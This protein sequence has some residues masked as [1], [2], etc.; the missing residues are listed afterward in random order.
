MEEVKHNDMTTVGEVATYNAAKILPKKV[1]RSVRK[2]ARAVD[3]TTGKMAEA[4]DQMGKAVTLILTGFD[5]MIRK[6]RILA[7]VTKGWSDRAT[8]LLRTSRG[9]LKKKYM[10]RLERETRIMRKRGQL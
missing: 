8:H 6:A 2:L 10:N 7:I 1:S 9:R 4:A 5:E 3:E